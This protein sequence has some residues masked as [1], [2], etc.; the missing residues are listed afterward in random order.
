MANDS[1]RSILLVAF[2]FLLYMFRRDVRSQDSSVLESD[3]SLYGC[4]HSTE[5][6]SQNLLDLVR[7]SVSVAA[8]SSS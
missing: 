4:F 2:V 3:P 1:A 5:L 7:V 8:G 6:A